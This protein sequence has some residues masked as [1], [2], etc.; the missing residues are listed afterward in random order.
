MSILVT[1]VLVIFAFSAG[2]TLGTFIAGMLFS[3]R[4]PGD[5]E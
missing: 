4:E 5:R 3:A 1:T 2:L